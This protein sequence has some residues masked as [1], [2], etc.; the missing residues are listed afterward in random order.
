MQELV[1]ELTEELT[2]SIFE[3]Y[4]SGELSVRE[5]QE[6]YSLLRNW[7]REYYE[8]TGLRTK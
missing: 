4:T 1:Q 5:L 6:K 8:L 3:K 7:E 2:E